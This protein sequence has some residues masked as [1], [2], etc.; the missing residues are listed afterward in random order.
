M[1]RPARLEGHMGG[2]QWEVWV[3]R[4]MSPSTAHL[5]T[6]SGCVSFGVVLTHPL[7]PSPASKA[8]QEDTD[9]SD[10]LPGHAR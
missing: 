1:L 5:P 8:G 2:R 4:A 9:H 3:S 6:P 7:P 10:V